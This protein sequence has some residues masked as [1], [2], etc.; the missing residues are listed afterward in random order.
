MQMDANVMRVRIITEEKK[1]SGSVNFCAFSDCGLPRSLLLWDLARGQLQLD[2]IPDRSET[3][4]S[5]IYPIL[6][7]SVF[8]QNKG[9]VASLDKFGISA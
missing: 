1:I 5:Y 4:S 9:F 8:W 2:W 3:V 7:S 6:S